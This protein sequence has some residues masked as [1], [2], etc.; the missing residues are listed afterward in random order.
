MRRL[1]KS[2]KFNKGFSLIEVL[3]AMAVI[4]LISIPL[5]RTFVTSAQI[6]GKAKKLQNATDIA[7]NVSENF[8]TVPLLNLVK[9]NKDDRTVCGTYLLDTSN[10]VIVFQNLGDG[11]K[12]ENN[13]PYF[14]GADGEKFYVTVTM[15]PDEYAKSSD[16]VGVQ[17]INN[18]IVPSMGDL[19]STDVVTAYSQFTKYDN[20]IVTAFKN[21][22]P[23]VATFQG[24]GFEK[25]SIKKDTY[26]YIEQYKNG[27]YVNYEYRLKLVYTYCTSHSTDYVE[28]AYFVDYSFT[29]AQGTLSQYEKMPELFLLYTPFDRYDTACPYTFARDEIHIEYMMNSSVTSGVTPDW[30]RETKVYIVEQDV[31]KGLNKNYIYLAHHRWMSATAMNNFGVTS[32]HCKKLE[33]YSTVDGWQQNVTAGQDHLLELYEMNVY[34][35]YDEPDPNSAEDYGKGTANLD[36]VYTVVEAIKEEKP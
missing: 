30:E 22:Y 8:A 28:S 29:L 17:D 13:I 2:S 3:V 20:S 9:T 14:K 5:L 35:W 12:D 32:D 7:Q 1:A 15:N 11:S 33:I 21:K 4:T 18:Y 25:A 23:D 27:D 10:D 34:V 6:N 16:I 19:F 36:D 24:S 26:V 31:V